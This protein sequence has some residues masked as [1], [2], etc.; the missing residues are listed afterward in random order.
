[1]GVD[2]QPLLFLPR[3]KEAKYYMDFTE[4]AVWKLRNVLFLNRNW[5][6]YFNFHEEAFKVAEGKRSQTCFQKLYLQSEVQDAAHAVL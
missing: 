3:V 1:M 4:T 6:D 2:G 5:E